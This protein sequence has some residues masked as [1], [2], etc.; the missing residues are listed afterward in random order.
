MFWLPMLPHDM[1]SLR[2]ETTLR[3]HSMKF[4]SLTR[5]PADTEGKNPKRFFF[6]N[7]EDPS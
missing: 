4:S 5:H 1:R 7:L 6:G 3:L 2:F